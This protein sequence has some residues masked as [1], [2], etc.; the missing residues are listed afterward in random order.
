MA[1]TWLPIYGPFPRLIGYGGE[2]E[3]GR[4]R[5]TP[6][7]A[8]AYLGSILVSARCESADHH[9]DRRAASNKLVKAEPA[10]HPKRT[11]YVLRCTVFSGFDLPLLGLSPLSRRAPTALGV[12]VT[13]G[14]LGV[15][16][17]K[18][19]PSSA[20]ASGSAGG[21]CVWNETLQ[22]VVSLPQG[23]LPDVILYLYSGDPLK[24]P[25]LTISAM[26]ALNLR[27]GQPPFSSADS[28]VERGGAFCPIAFCRLPSARLAG[29]GTGG[30]APEWLPLS[31]DTA[32]NAL[33]DAAGAGQVLARLA[34]SE[35]VE[36]EGEV[37]GEVEDWL[38]Q[39]A[40][41]GEWVPYELR[42]HL[43]RG[44]DLPAGDADGSADPQVELCFG[45]QSVRSSTRPKTRAPGWFETLRLPS[46][47][48]CSNLRLAP[49]VCL[50]VYDIDPPS[51][52]G[53]RQEDRLG[54]LR[55]ALGRSHTLVGSGS[56]AAAA[57]LSARPRWYRLSAGGSGSANA[58]AARGGGG[59]SCPGQ[60]RVYLSAHSQGLAGGGAAAAA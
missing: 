7:A 24:C 45:G 43:Y 39:S 59:G 41:A 51:V 44:R 32:V 12:L 23:P 52:F 29:A 27:L 60:P 26:P 19:S 55:Y 30:L 56:A 40:G 48:V 42:C 21:T 57:P 46:V 4:M 28:N 9:Q 17:Q 6:A 25:Y 5:T 22:T 53:G 54:E 36:G 34:L 1:P 31:E 10:L 14:G 47:L 58:A 3:A 18:L 15:A 50:T 35:V 16:T 33:P 8:P 20:P 11:L 2:R 38:A 37:G 49:P 13:I